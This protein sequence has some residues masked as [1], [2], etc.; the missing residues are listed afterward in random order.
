MPLPASIM[1]RPIAVPEAHKLANT[2]G[3]FQT[4]SLSCITGVM[5]K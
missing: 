3:F 5:R 1:P 4:G 2:S